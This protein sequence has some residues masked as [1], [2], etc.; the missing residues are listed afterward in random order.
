[1]PCLKGKRGNKR[2]YIYIYMEREGGEEERKVVLPSATL[3]E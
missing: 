2:V 1:M 3:F